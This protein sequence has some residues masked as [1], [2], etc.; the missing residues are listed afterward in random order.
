MIYKLLIGVL[1]TGCTIIEQPPVVIGPNGGAGTVLRDNE[2]VAVQ[3]GPTDALLLRSRV[4][5]IRT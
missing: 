5:Y 3:Q 4:A 1:L 2:C